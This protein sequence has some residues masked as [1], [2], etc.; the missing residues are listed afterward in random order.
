MTRV[1]V[2]EKTL[3]DLGRGGGGGGGRLEQTEHIWGLQRA[4][5][6]S[7]TFDMSLRLKR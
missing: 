7:L 3:K 4:L 2:G 5:H 6:T 1:R